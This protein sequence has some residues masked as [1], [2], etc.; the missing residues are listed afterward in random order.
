MQVKILTINTFSRNCTKVMKMDTLYL[1]PKM[2]PNGFTAIMPMM[3]KALDKLIN[4][5]LSYYLQ[6]NKLLKSHIRK[7][8]RL[9]I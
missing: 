3:A 6:T 4:R 7:L 2:N 9:A 8:Q 1:I 5:L